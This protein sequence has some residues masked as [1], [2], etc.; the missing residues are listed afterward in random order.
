MIKCLRAY[1]IEKQQALDPKFQ[2]Y[3]YRHF[4]EAY[5]SKKLPKDIMQEVKE[6]LK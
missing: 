2:N 6:V 4:M 3:N 5:H 1:Y